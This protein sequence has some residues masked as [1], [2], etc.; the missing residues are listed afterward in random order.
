MKHLWR[1]CAGVICT[2]AC[3]PVASA[4]SSYLLHDRER[5]VTEAIEAID[6]KIEN[7]EPDFDRLFYQPI[8][9]THG[10]ADLSAARTLLSNNRDNIFV[11]SPDHQIETA[12]LNEEGDYDWHTRPCRDW[13]EEIV[14]ANGK[15]LFS[16]YCGNPVRRIIY[17]ETIPASFPSHSVPATPRIKSWNAEKQSCTPAAAAW[18]D[19]TAFHSPISPFIVNSSI[20]KYHGVN[21]HFTFLGSPSGGSYAFEGSSMMRSCIYNGPIVLNQTDHSQEN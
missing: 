19:V 13:G 8:Q 9:D 18:S 11:C 15:P 1:I 7:L 21:S 3:V 6:V 2:L 20:G 17:P 14:M 4:G 5:T 16:V 10:L 12:F